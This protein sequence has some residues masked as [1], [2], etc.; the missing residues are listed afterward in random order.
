[1][2]LEFLTFDSTSFVI[3]IIL[4]TGAILLLVGGW[5]KKRLKSK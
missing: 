4:W 3:N 1:M 2:L 5:I